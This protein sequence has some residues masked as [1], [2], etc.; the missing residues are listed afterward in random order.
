MVNKPQPDPAPAPQ[1]PR[2]D[3]RITLTAVVLLLLPFCHNFPYGF[4]SFLRLVICGY[5]AFNAWL[6]YQK[7]K[8]RIPFI[9][10]VLFAVLFNPFVKMRFKKDEWLTIDA[11]TIGVIVILAAAESI[12]SKKTKE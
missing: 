7:N 4:Y 3:F 10:S 8:I 6:T 2:M 11:I 5:F 9:I 12:M 1:K